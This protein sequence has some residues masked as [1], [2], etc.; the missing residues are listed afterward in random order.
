[1]ETNTGTRSRSVC[2]KGWFFF[3]IKTYF[4]FLKQWL[5]CFLQK[6]RALKA[7][8][9]SGGVFGVM[10]IQGGDFSPGAK[11]I[12]WKNR[13]VYLGSCAKKQAPS[14]IWWRHAR[15]F[16]TYVIQGWI[17][18]QL[19]RIAKNATTCLFASHLGYVYGVG[20]KSTARSSVRS[21]LIGYFGAVNSDYFSQRR[22]MPAQVIAKGLHF[23]VQLKCK[24]IFIECDKL[25][26]HWVIAYPIRVSR[27]RCKFPTLPAFLRRSAFIYVPFIKKT[28]T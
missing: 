21:Y 7:N 18:L 4:V 23:P 15:T 19:T 9:P 3:A 2:I 14:W 28:I 6:K 25:I 5:L 1:M 8:H 13:R 12:E 27:M 17:H 11:A 10:G 22:K 24:Y 20:D 26:L 16:V